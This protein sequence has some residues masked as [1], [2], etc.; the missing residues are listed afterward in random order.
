MSNRKRSTRKL[1]KRVGP[2]ETAPASLIVTKGAK[3]EVEDL[4]KLAKSLVK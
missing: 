4:E 1:R 3:S 2:I